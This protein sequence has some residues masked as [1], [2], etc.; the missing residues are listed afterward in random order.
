MTE[1]I[2][3][4][5]TMT[6]PSTGEVNW[7]PIYKDA[8]T[9]I[10]SHDHTGSGNGVQLG[11][12][13]LAADA[14]T[15]AKIRLDNNQYLRARNAANSADIDILKVNSSDK[16]EFGAALSWTT[17]SPTL[18]GGGTISLSGVTVH[19]SKYF[20][21]GK[22]VSVAVRAT[23]TVSGT[24]TFIQIPLPVTAGSVYAVQG[25]SG[26]LTDNGITYV[27]LVGGDTT[28]AWVYL[29]GTPNLTAALGS[30][31]FHATYEAA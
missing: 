17:Y 29:T 23:Y 2:S 22:L 3:A 14:V 8:F 28:N 19:Y 25:A 18:S 20:Q 21:M 12:S 5:I 11:T 1:T 30:V 13:A 31:A 27:A 24:G 7:G 9:E 6:I 4:G 16:I 15:G 26:F 10:S